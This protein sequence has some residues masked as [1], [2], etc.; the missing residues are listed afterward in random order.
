[1][2]TAAVAKT[3][4][5]YLATGG[6]QATDIVGNGSRVYVKRFIYIPAVDA[7]TCVLVD[8]RIGTSVFKTKGAAAGTA[9]VYD[10]GGEK[11]TPY[12]GLNVTLSGAND[13]LHVIAA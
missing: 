10:V 11:G 7:D 9:Y 3:S 8:T 4:Y 2:A 6:T 1:M 13:E 5:G 12:E